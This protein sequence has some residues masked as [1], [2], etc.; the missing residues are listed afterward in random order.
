VDPGPSESAWAVYDS[1]EDDIVE[2]GTSINLEVKYDMVGIERIRSYGQV[3]SNAVLETAE[4]VGFL[5]RVFIELKTRVHLIPRRTIVNHLTGT[6]VGGDKKVN[7]A[8]NLICPNFA[9]KR[10]G[11]NGHHRAAAAVA[12]TCYDLYGKG[13]E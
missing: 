7:A 12:I 2:W 4:Q 1:K 11:L 10:K 8:V 3:V 6:A 9:A 13:V 5:E